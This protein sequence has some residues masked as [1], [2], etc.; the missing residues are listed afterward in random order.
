MLSIVGFALTVR[1]RLGQRARP[2]ALLFESVLRILPPPPNSTEIVRLAHGSC[3]HQDKAQDFWRTLQAF[4][5]QLFVFNGDI[6][7]GDCMS[8]A[9]PEL[10]SA[11]DRMFANVHMRTAAAVQPMVGVL[12]D[13]D[14]GLNDCDASNPWKGAAKQEFLRRFGVPTSDPVTARPGVYRAFEFGGEGRRLQLLLLDT[15]WS[16]SALLPTDCPMCEGKE[17]YV[18]YNDSGGSSAVGADGEKLAMLGEEQWAWLEEQLRRPA[19]LRLLVST[20]QVLAQGHGWE[21]WGLIPSELRRLH[22]LVA[23]TAAEGVVILSGDRHAGGVYRLAAGATGVGYDLVEVTASSLTHSYRTTAPDEPAGGEEAACGVREGPLVRENH[24]GTVEVD[25]ASRQLTLGL[26][27]ADDC[28]LS[29]ACACACACACPVGEEQ[30]AAI[31]CCA[32]APD[33]AG[34]TLRAITLSFEELRPAV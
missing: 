1:L 34:Q 5:P 26:V 27:A 11:W 23:A 24:F 10:P 28:G 19:D 29:D 20:V 22:A 4:A 2:A 13:H 25:W 33:G 12:D 21:R 18:P 7:Y 31:G 3:A 17:R 15:R 14:Y 6:V 30:E 8:A 16:R 32:G 9:C